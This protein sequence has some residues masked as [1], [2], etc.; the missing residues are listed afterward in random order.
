VQQPLRVL[1]LVPQLA[2]AVPAGLAAAV[3]AAVHVAALLAAAAAAS[4][5]H[6][7]FAQVAPASCAQYQIGHWFPVAAVAAEGAAADPAAAAAAV[8]LH[9]AHPCKG[10]YTA[11]FTAERPNIRL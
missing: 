8:A 2:P 10:E 4:G 11:L 6:G 1:V 9:A 5:C 7:P 3:Q